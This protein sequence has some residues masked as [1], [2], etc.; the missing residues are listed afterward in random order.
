VTL[1][2]IEE[3]FGNGAAQRLRTRMEAAMASVSIQAMRSDKEKARQDALAFLK[4]HRTGVLATISRNYEPHASAVHYTADDKFNVY[5][6]TRTNSRKF[7]A[8][9]AHPQVA[10]TVAVDHVPQTLQIEGMAANISDTDEARVKK[11]ELFEIHSKNLLF[12]AP[13]SKMDPHETAIIWIQPRWI[14]WSD[15]AFAEDGDEHVFQEIPVGG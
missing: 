3:H 9:S 8:L 1:D 6:V 10:F 11:D 13:I 2:Q 15:Y 7:D 5:I 4:H 14:R 12:Y